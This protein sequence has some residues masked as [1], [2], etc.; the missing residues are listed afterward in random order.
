[1]FHRKIVSLSKKTKRSCQGS[2]KTRRQSRHNVF[3]FYAFKKKKKIIIQ[4]DLPKKLQKFL[5][6]KI[7]SNK[8]QNTNEINTVTNFAFVSIILLTFFRVLRY[9]QT[10][11]TLKYCVSRYLMRTHR[12]IYHRLNNKLL[13]V[14]ILRLRKV[15]PKRLP[16]IIKTSNR[17]KT[18]SFTKLI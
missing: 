10:A 2:F 8:F 6:V 9:N 7:K 5:T 16:T 18:I 1:M 4:N 11:F 13:D 15:V 17:R 12:Q 3:I 14:F